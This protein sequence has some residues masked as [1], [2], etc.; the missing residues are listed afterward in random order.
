MTK[1]NSSERYLL[2]K[3]ADTLK[4]IQERGLGKWFQ[5]DMIT[6]DVIPI[7]QSHWNANGLLAALGQPVDPEPDT[8]PQEEKDQDLFQPFPRYQSL[9]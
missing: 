9:W 6:G 3:I 4:K 1:R 8:R 7:E 5:V 2:D